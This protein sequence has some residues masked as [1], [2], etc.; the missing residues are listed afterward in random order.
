MKTIFRKQTFSVKDADCITKCMKFIESGLSEAA[1]KKRLA[2]TV[3]LLSEESL[4]ALID[5]APQDADIL[6]RI[7]KFLGD[8]T[9]NISAPGTELDIFDRDIESLDEAADEDPIEAYRALILKAYGENLKYVNKKGVNRVRIM[10]GQAEQSS[11]KLTFAALALGVLFGLVMKMMLS[12]AACDVIC[13]F[14]LSP[15]STMFMN[16]LKIVI[17]PVVFFS[18]VT[19]ISGFGNLSELG[20]IGARVMIMYFI[21]TVLAVIMSFCVTTL[22]SPGKFGAGLAMAG[23][24]SVDIN[25]DVDTSLLNTI[26]N[27]IPSNFVEPFLQA[28]TLQLIFL[29]VMIGVA[30]GKIGEYTPVLKEFFEACNSLFLTLT[31]M[32]ARFIPLAVF[33]SVSLMVVNLGGS[34]FL[35]LLG[36][37]GADIIE[38]FLMLVIYALIILIVGRLK[39]SVF[40]I[41]NREGMITSFTL[42][43]SSAAL[44]VN[45]RTCTDKMGISP[46]VCNFSLPLGATINMDGTC[47]G[48]VLSGL[49][50]A[51]MYGVTVTPSML[52]P[53]AITI[54]LLSLGCPG[55]PGAG[56]VCIGIVLAQIGVPISAIGLIIAVNPITDMFCTMSN[57]TGDVATALITAKKEGLLDEEV[58]YDMSRK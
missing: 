46:K 5:S 55:V 16:A 8:T 44:P 32:I 20:R 1:V 35:S 14:V 58:F 18:I 41:K 13:N 17:A 30:V 49:F 28:D 19:C 22:I 2:I 42:S 51:K 33:C 53:L 39:P 50:L 56:L 57:T 48:L 47:I 7:W 9:I 23:A 43:S 27:V 38:I 45:L 21:T 36:Y 15:V 37:V 6:I 31:A 24:Q 25:T 3:R 34:S 10:A 40:F 12:P 54:I 52:A 26:I 11:V 29:A 4:T